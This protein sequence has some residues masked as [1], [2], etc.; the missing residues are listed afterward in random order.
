[1]QNIMKEAVSKDERM[2]MLFV[3]VKNLH[4]MPLRP[5]REVS[6]EKEV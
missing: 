3:H 4:Q 2:C 6:Y 5:Y 1:M